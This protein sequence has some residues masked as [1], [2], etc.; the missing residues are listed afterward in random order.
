MSSQEL[1]EDFI[2]CQKLIPPCNLT[3]ESELLATK[4]F[5]YKLALQNLQFT[6][7]EGEP[8]NFVEIGRC[9]EKLE[10]EFEK[11]TLNK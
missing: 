3:C 1:S 4:I 2:Q 9:F 6:I 7:F 11:N 5:R 10:E 8:N